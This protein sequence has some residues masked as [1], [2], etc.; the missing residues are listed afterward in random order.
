MLVVRRGQ[1]VCGVHLF[2]GASSL[3]E[4]APHASSQ[5][6]GKHSLFPLRM[7]DGL[8]FLTHD[9]AEAGHS[10]HVMYAV[11]HHP[12]LVFWQ[13]NSSNSKGGVPPASRRVKSDR[14]RCHP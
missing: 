7:E 12:L 11:H 8:V 13:L 10:A 4:T 5:P 1:I 14:H 2:E 3:I 6:H 9:R